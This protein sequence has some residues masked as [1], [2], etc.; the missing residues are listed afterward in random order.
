MTTTPVANPRRTRLVGMRHDNACQV[1]GPQCRGTAT[2]VLH[3]PDGD[4]PS[5]ATCA[6]R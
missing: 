5:C 3:T 6:G 1:A 2:D 4:R